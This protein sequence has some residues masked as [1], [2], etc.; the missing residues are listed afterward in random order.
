M[1][2]GIYAVYSL[3]GELIWACGLPSSLQYRGHEAPTSRAPCSWASRSIW[4][5]PLG[6]GRLAREFSLDLG[7]EQQLKLVL[8]LELQGRFVSPL[9]SPPLSWE[10]TG[11]IFLSRC[12]FKNSYKHG[13]G[14]GFLCQRPREQLL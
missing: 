2:W 14:R 7:L 4:S 9:V 5:L 13:V 1:D 6:T 11:H 8:G 12:L 3:P 10:G